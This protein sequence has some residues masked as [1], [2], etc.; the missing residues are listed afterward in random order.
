MSEFD[1][2]LFAVALG[3]GAVASVCGF[4]IGS[5]LTPVLCL[6]VDTKLAIALVSISH[7]L[8]TFARGWTLRRHVDRAVLL[9]FGIL[10][11]LGGLAGA[12]FHS[13]TQVTTLTVCFGAILVFSGLT[14]ATRISERWQFGPRTAWAAGALS[15]FLGGM[16]GNQGGIRSAALLGIR[17]SPET[18][19]G[20]AT[21]IGLLVDLARVPVYLATES[22]AI[23]AHGR[24]VAIASAG[25]LAGTYLGMRAL[26]RIPARSFKRVVSAAILALGAWMIAQGLRGLLN[27]S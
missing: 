7:F 24:L 9:H 3:A 8:G 19:V 27:Y 4:G 20:T 1:A 14:G 13:E 22:A 2:L 10:S 17:A 25:V 15:G 11:A 18:F 23:V 26:R 6:V 12:L 5:L 16:V 21:A